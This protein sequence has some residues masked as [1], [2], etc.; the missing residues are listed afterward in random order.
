M[1]SSMLPIKENRNKMD[2]A[3]NKFKLKQLK[4]QEN[5]FY[6]LIAKFGFFIKFFQQKRNQTKVIK[7]FLNE[8][9]A[10]LEKIIK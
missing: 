7:C 6:F 9:F 4:N 8:K 1:F 10:N 3:K 5:M 2:D